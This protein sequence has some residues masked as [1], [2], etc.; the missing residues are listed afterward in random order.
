MIVGHVLGPVALG[1]YL[2]GV[3]HLQ[4]GSRT[5]RHGRALRLDPG[6]SR[7]AEHGEEPLSRG[8]RKAITITALV[9]TPVGVGLATLAPAL[10]AALYGESWLP[11]SG[12]LRFLAVVM[13]ARMFTTLALDLQT[14]LGNTKVPCSSTPPGS[15]PLSPRCFSA[16]DGV[17]Y[18]AAAASAVVA[19][20]VAIPLI[21]ASCTAQAWT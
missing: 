20:V 2:L 18:G 4:L 15:S 11:S 8:A 5:G 9:A 10:V 7:L 17:A 13:F 19:V 1:F 21:V 3:Q 6:F 14:S 12:P 16:P